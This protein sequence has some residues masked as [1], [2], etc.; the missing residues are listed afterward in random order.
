MATVVTRYNADDF[1]QIMFDGFSYELTPDTIALIQNLADQVGAPEYIRTPQFPKRDRDRGSYGGDSRS[2]RGGGGRR[3]NRNQEISDD[4]W[5][6]IRT[7]QATE[8]AKKEGIDASIDLIRKHLNKMSDKT[9]DSL[10]AKIFE[11]LCNVASDENPSE[12]VLAEC[13]KVGDAV[14]AIAS[15]NRFY[16]EMYARLYKEL[17][18]RFPFMEGIFN[19]NFDSFGAVFKTIE[20]CSPD[21]DYDKFC[22][23][24][25]TNEQRRALSAFYVNLMNMEVISTGAIAEI[26]REVQTQF[27]TLSQQE[28]KNSIVD[29]LSEVIYILVTNGAGKLEEEDCWDEIISHVENVSKMK[30][31]SAPSITNKAIFKHM[32]LMDALE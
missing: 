17:M 8:I 3:R 30:V 24:N 5:E 16:S 29:E 1:N 15:S 20:Y 4:D 13:K 22:E 2:G 11:E 18:A 27:T 23:I 21:E 14:F 7:F 28:D 12:E 31:S 32:D 25:K 10:S 19:N 9:Y 6:Q 26:T